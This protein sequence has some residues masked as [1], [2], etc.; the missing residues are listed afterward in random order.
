MQIKKGG[1]WVDTQWADTLNNAAISLTLSLWSFLR[2]LNFIPVSINFS[3]MT[4]LSH[5]K[6]AGNQVLVLFFSSMK[7]IT[8]SVADIHVF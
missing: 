7:S 8:N 1:G 3:V 5:C 4:P 6:K 2:S